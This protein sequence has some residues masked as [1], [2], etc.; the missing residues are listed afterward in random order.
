MEAERKYER[1]ETIT[2][3]FCLQFANLNIHSLFLQPRFTMVLQRQYNISIHY[4]QDKADV[5]VCL[6]CSLGF[7]FSI[8]LT[9]KAR[10]LFIFLK[11]NR[12]S[13]LGAPCCSLF[14]FLN[15][16]LQ[17]LFIVRQRRKILVKRRRMNSYI[18][19]N[20]NRNINK[21][22]TQMLSSYHF[23]KTSSLFSSLHFSTGGRCTHCLNFSMALPLFRMSSALFLLLNILREI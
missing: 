14:C 23:F 11:Q 6:D 10:E 15:L 8:L 21:I 4:Q 16:P 19:S 1:K 20:N 9:Y 13:T 5:K 12:Y 17:R 7:F 22:K 18:I 2:K 3:T